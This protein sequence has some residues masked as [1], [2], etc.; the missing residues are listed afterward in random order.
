MVSPG[1]V[2]LEIQNQGGGSK[3][4]I[5]KT[6]CLS[7]QQ[8][9][10]GFQSCP[11]TL[12]WSEHDLDRESVSFENCYLDKARDSNERAKHRAGE[13]S[14]TPPPGTASGNGR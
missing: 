1:K 6:F 5:D 7:W 4:S 3:E 12:A 2:F 8:S 11:E 13:S 10:L 9:D 14:L